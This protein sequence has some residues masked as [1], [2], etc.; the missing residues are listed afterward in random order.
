MIVNPYIPYTSY[1]LEKNITELKNKYTFLTTSSIGNSILGK[2]L[3]LIKI[4]N[5]NKKVGYFASFHANESITTNLMMKFLENL[6]ESYYYKS[7]IIG[8]DIQR[9]L[10]QVTIYIVPMVNPDGVD[11]VNGAISEK[12]IAFSNAKHIASFFPSIPFTSGWK[13]NIRG[14]DLNLQYPAEW[15]K[16]RQIKFEQGYNKPAPRDF[17]GYGPLTEPEALAIYNLALEENFDLILCYHT[18]GK[19]IYWQFQNYAPT[20]AYTIGLELS[21]ISGYTLTTPDITSSFAGFKDWFLQ[22]Y[23]K[24]AYTIEA[25]IGTNPLP[26][27]QFDQIY[28]DNIGILL[29]AAQ[30]I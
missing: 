18:Q 11:L 28:K 2:S 27:S 1:L 13:A 23:Q 26:L 22:E 6:S 10:S 17:V 9:L 29:K 4:G 8:I 5:G 15:L 24:P 25:G 3:A 7:S 14:V 16:A 19:E 20:R 21:R 12:S 30:L